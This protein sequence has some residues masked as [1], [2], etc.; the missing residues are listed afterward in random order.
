MPPFA[1]RG[2][3]GPLRP[4]Y[5]MPEAALAV[6]I[7]AWAAN[8]SLVKFAVDLG[9]PYGFSLVRV[10]AALVLLLPAWR[11][12]PRVRKFEWK[13]APAFLFLGITG[14]A[15]FQVGYIL[16]TEASSATSATLILALTPAAIAVI[17]WTTNAE[18]FSR[19]TAA[20]LALSL[21]GIALISGAEPDLST[22]LGNLGLFAAMLAWAFYTVRSAPLVRKYGAVRVTLVSI[23]IGI[24]LLF[25]PAGFF[26]GPEDFGGLPTAWWVTAVVSGA[27][28][29]TLAH[30]LWGYATVRLGPTFTGICSNLVPIPALLVSSM[31]LGEQLDATRIAGALLIVG[32]IV[33]ARIRT[34]GTDGRVRGRAPA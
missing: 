7:A 19:A 26:L 9:N 22:H 1:S 2:S 13:D 24:V 17:A 18:P 31:W 12:T 30:I 25:L 5:G 10:S 20:G 23:S 16:G 32:G 11:L 8:F 14:H 27:G 15:G 3:V 21:V 29:I 6:V 34:L 33:V 28:A 4:R